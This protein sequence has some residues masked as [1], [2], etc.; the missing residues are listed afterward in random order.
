MDDLLSAEAG[1]GA[2][3]PATELHTLHTDPHGDKGL[4]RE[5]GLL[6]TSLSWHKRFITTPPTLHG[7]K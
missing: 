6:S 1:L 3:S 2:A 4:R 5:L 7:N